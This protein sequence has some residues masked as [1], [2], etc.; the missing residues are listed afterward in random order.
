[1]PTDKFLL[2]SLPVALAAFVAGLLAVLRSFD[3]IRVPVPSEV[4][5]YDYFHLSS[6]SS[7]V[8][9]PDTIP[10]MFDVAR[11]PANGH[12]TLEV[13]DLRLMNLTSFADKANQT[14][15]KS[16]PAF[17]GYMSVTEVLRQKKR[18]PGSYPMGDLLLVTEVSFTGFD[19]ESGERE[20]LVLETQRVRRFR[21]KNVQYDEPT[22]LLFGQ[23]D[24][25]SEQTV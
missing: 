22:E 11:Y 2:W 20:L 15:E 19:D 23:V 16:S 6:N 14:E 12:Q 7:T 3:L 25:I 18:N 9:L 1:M 4:K 5:S 10:L 8:H 13:H 21:L 24:W 17:L